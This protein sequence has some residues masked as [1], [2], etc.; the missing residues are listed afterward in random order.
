MDA[1]IDFVLSSE[2]ISHSQQVVPDLFATQTICVHSRSFAAILS[3]L[4]MRAVELT[5]LVSVSGASAAAQDRIV[6]KRGDGRLTVSGVIEDYTGKQITVRSPQGN[7]V[8]NYDAADILE[9]ETP[10]TERHTR[11]LKLLAEQQF[12]P[13]LRELEVALKDEKRL[14]VR[15]EILALLIKGALRLG[16]YAS[17]GMRFVTLYDSDP[18]TRHFPL[19]PLIWGPHPINEPL[20]TEAQGWL[21]RESDL[22][23]LMGASVLLFDA[24]YGEPSRAAIKELSSSPDTRVRML[25]QAQGWRLEVTADAPGELQLKRWQS[26]LDEMPAELRSGPCYLLGH[27]QFSRR[28][29]ELAAATLLWLPTADDHD[30]HLAARACLEAGMALAAIGQTNEAA[31]LFREVTVRFADTPFAKEATAQLK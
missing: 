16:N 10:Q 21:V 18:A 15:R 24:R 6:L 2:F 22:A 26:R 20:R 27:A 4:L 23:R 7:A 31:T 25:A 19:I 5:L 29:Y 8:N 12:E 17:A 30:H 14:W 1:N 13:A 3:C 11:G 9:I 28:D